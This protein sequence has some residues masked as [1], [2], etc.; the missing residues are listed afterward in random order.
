MR[1][2]FV[3]ALL[4]ASSCLIAT[5]VGRAQNAATSPMPNEI[6]ADLGTCSAQISVTG[7]D[8]KPVY[9]AKVTTRIQY[10]LLGVKRLDLEG[11]TGPNGRMKI[12]KLPEALKKPMYI[13]ISKNDE[14]HVVEFKPDRHCQA[15]FDVQLGQGSR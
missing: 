14:D 10:G 13:H 5:S 1:I 3:P 6:S 12:I 11:Y 8:L 2:L 4:L 15:E 9:G 7:T